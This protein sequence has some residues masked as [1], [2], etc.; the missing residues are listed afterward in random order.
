MTPHSDRPTAPLHAEDLTDA[1]GMTRQGL[2]HYF[3]SKDD[4]L[5]RLVTDVTAPFLEKLEAIHEETD[6]SSVDE[7]RDFTPMLAEDRARNRLRFRA[8]D[9]SASCS[10]VPSRA[11]HCPLTPAL[12]KVTAAVGSISTCAATARNLSVKIESRC[13]LRAVSPAD[14]S[15]S[16]ASGPH[17]WDRASRSIRPCST[18]DTWNRPR[19]TS[20]GTSPVEPPAPT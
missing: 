12:E 16:I 13:T 3:R 6:R 17:R 14:T 4:I 2:H 19:R 7:L 18:S 15:A 1:A 5:V 10:S 8:L 11:P 9:R 20:P